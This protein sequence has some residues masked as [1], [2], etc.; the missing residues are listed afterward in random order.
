MSALFFHCFKICDLHLFFLDFN[1]FIF[2][3][4]NLIDFCSSLKKIL[5][6]KFE[7]WNLELKIWTWKFEI[8]NWKFWNL[9]LKIWN[10][11]LKIWKLAL[12]VWDIFSRIM[13]SLSLVISKKFLQSH[14][15]FFLIDIFWSFEK[16]SF[17]LFYFS[18][19]WKER[20]EKRNFFWELTES[21]Q[22]NLSWLS[23][24]D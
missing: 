24:L 9:E 10:L 17:I 22:S 6:L 3:K 15:F 18:F 19:S 11:G 23:N 16:F 12:R 2:S 4:K 5:S 8:W 20:K 7:T 1:F 13:V 14:N 21:T